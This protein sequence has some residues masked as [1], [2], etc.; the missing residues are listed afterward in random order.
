MMVE[1]GCGGRIS[2]E[3]TSLSNKEE[4]ERTVFH[5]THLLQQVHTSLS[6][7][8]VP[9]I[10]EKVFKHMSLWGPFSLNSAQYT[11]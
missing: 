4:V 1:R 9:L 8:I 11:Q 7:Q 5:N 2:R 3:L 10:E 6:F